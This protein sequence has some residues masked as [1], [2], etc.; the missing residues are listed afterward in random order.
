M[1]FKALQYRRRAMPGA[2]R[3]PGRY[4]LLLMSG[5]PDAESL[6]GII[7]F[8]LAP[9]RADF[10]LDL[11]ALER[12]V[13]WLSSYGFCAINVPAGISEAYSLSPGEAVEMARIAV[14]AAAGRKPVIGCVGCNAAVAAETAR[15]MEA[16]GAA[17]LLVLPPYYPNAPFEGLL[18]YYRNIGAATGLPLCLYS[19]GW[20]SFTPAQAARLAEAV[21]TLQLWKDGQA[22]AR[23]LQRIMGKLGDRL[24]WIGGAGDD[25]A[26][27]Y[28][29]IGIRAFTSSISAVAPRLALHW[30]EAAVRGE[31]DRLGRILERYVHPL[32][33]L[34]TRRTGYEVAVM[35]K[36]RELIGRPAGPPRPPL[37]EFDPADL[38]ELGRIIQSWQDFLDAP[39]GRS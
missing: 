15:R 24:V 38:A 36:A 21:P 14:K 2:Q 31:L 26:A 4:R 6:Q 3:R 1:R 30:G 33:E 39:A 19:R 32:F 13:D 23:R 10:S 27:A 20:A 29:A 18:G 7:G 8:P 34:R 16:A 17:A 37:P 12:D 9:F 35:K 22:D 11:A 28:R 25:C 5:Q